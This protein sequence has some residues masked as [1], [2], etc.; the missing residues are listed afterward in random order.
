[1][2]DKPASNKKRGAD[3]KSAAK[4]CQIVICHKAPLRAPLGAVGVTDRGT[5]PL[6]AE[7]FNLKELTP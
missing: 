5:Q 4:T 3:G 1:V 7:H 6:P 2:H